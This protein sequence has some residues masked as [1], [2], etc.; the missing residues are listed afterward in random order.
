MKFGSFIEYG[1]RDIFLKK[2]YT[3]CC[4]KNIPTSSFFIVFQVDGY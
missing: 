4:E 2:S 3:R 1:M